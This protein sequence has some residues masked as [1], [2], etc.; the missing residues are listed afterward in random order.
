MNIVSK[1]K[2]NGV[3]RRMLY[4]QKLLMNFIIWNAKVVNNSEFRRHCTSMVKLYNPAILVLLKTNMP[5]Y[6]H[7][8]TEP[9]FNSQI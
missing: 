1:G 7:L 3:K 9:Q 4:Q 2:E 5:D 6:K 8:A